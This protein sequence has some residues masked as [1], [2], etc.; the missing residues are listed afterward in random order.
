MCKASTKASR[1]RK[2]KSSGQTRQNRQ[3]D[4]RGLLY[5]KPRLQVYKPSGGTRGVVTCQYQGGSR[6]LLSQHPSD[7]DNRARRLG[8][9]RPPYP[10]LT[11]Y[12]IPFL[13]L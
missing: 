13:L 9:A 8:A 10:K 1:V 5:G 7:V 12:A 6:D 11:N 3:L 2:V 4:T